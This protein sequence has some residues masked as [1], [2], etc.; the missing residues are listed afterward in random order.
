MNK[1]ET[2][3]WTSVVPI[4]PVIWTL[5]QWISF[6]FKLA[7]LAF[8]LPIIGFIIFDFCLWI[9]RQIRPPPKDS[10]RSNSRNP[11]PERARL[12]SGTGSSGS[13]SSSTKHASVVEKRTGYSAVSDR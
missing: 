10:S 2:M 11:S 5:I 7:S 1:L 13:T 9:Y 4:H 6:F 8:A 3:T 12:S